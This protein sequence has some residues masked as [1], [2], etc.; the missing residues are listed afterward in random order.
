[1]LLHLLEGS[2]FNFL[3]RKPGTALIAKIEKLVNPKGDWKKRTVKETE[4]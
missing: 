3:T 1:M 2:C 4:K